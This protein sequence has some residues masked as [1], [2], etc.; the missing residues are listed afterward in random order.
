MSKVYATYS[1]FV[2]H[3][4]VPVEIH[5]GD[6][7][8]DDHPVVVANPHLFTEPQRRVTPRRDAREARRG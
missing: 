4:G 8:P 7:Y 6:E 5:D 1:G 3:M 2:G